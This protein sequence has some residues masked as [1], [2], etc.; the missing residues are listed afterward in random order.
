MGK[1]CM[2]Q[3]PSSVLP[4]PWKKY[5]EEG[6]Y[7]E[8]FEPKKRPVMC[9]SESALQITAAQ[10]LGWPCRHKLRETD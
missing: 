7:L 3:E 5:K 4:F 10:V 9:R 8:Y 1:Q 2:M 6:I